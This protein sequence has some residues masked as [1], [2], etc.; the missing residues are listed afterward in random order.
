MKLTNV[1]LVAIYDYRKVMT[2]GVRIT[3]DVLTFEFERNPGFH[4]PRL[5]L[6]FPVKVRKEK[7]Y[8]M[9]ISVREQEVTVHWNCQRIGSKNLREKYSFIPDSLGEIFLGKPLRVSSIE[10]YEV[11]LWSRETCE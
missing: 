2:L 11:R 1:Y 3:P 7:W 9:G 8:S 5:S 6:E 4:N 10:R